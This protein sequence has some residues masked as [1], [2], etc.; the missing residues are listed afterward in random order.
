M[1]KKNNNG[2]ILKQKGIRIAE[3]GEKL[4]RIEKDILK[5]LANF[6]KIQER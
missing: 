5:S 4:K 3:E 2:V 6:F 1:E